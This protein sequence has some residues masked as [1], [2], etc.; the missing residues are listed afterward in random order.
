MLFIFRFRPALVDC[1]YGRTSRVCSEGNNLPSLK[2]KLF[3]SIG[4]CNFQD[5][6]AVGPEISRVTVLTLRYPICQS[7]NVWPQVGL[8]K[9]INSEK[10]K[11]MCKMWK[12]WKTIL[13]IS[14]ELKSLHKYLIESLKNVEFNQS[15]FYFKLFLR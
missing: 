15:K 11:K 4:Q 2:Q 3:S 13:K 8:L 7:Q 1:I 12:V 6:V 14:P 9:K 10:Y 5:P